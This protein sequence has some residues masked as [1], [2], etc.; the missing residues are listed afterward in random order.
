M[1]FI[2]SHQDGTP[3]GR[4]GVRDGGWTTPLPGIRVRGNVD[5]SHRLLAEAAIH[6][7]DRTAVACDLTAAHMWSVTLPSGFGI[8]IDAQA[9]AIATVRD[10]SRHR[11]TG[12]RGRRLELPAAHLTTLDGVTITT[13]ARTWLDCAALVSITDVVAMGDAILRS[14]LATD[15]QLEEMVAWGRGR[16]GVRAARLG[17]PI[18]DGDAESPGESWVRGLLVLADIPRP[19]CNLPVTI[20]GWTFRLD[21]AWKEKRVAVEYDGAEYHG[22]EHQARDEWRRG[23]LAAAG[24]TV[25]VVRKEDFAHFE[26]II[27]AVRAALIG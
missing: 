21:M 27:R 22:P 9:C 11:A 20:A 24:W 18:L 12:L 2:R 23:L 14:R 5:L 3:I 19:V 25:I 17:L 6:V 13:P 26:R 8:D 7:S 16:R 10:G 15:R 1:D 4:I